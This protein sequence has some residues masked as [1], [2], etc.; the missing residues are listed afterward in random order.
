MKHY[1]DYKRVIATKEK[2]NGNDSVGDMWIETKS[3]DKSTEIKD[4]IEWAK[5]CSG[6]LIITIDEPELDEQF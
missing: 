5:D 4:I 3:F 2:S 6:K 1:K